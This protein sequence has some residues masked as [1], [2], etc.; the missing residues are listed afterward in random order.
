MNATTE[1]DTSYNHELAL[2]LEHLGLKVPSQLTG[3]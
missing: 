1:P 2:L 3:R